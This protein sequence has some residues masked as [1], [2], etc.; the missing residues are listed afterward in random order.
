MLHVDIPTL[1]DVKSLVAARAD[2]CVSIYL[3]TTP[4]TQKTA[5]SRI[6]LGNLWRGAA[7]QLE[8]AAFDKRR[9][10]ALE[11]QIADLA[12][13]RSFWRTQANSLAVLAT[14]ETLRTFRLPN[15]LV[16]Q[17]EVSDRFFLKP[18]LR[19]ITFPQVAFVLALSEG[20]VRLIEVFPDQPPNRVR[21]RAL[22]KDAGDATRRAS[23]NDRSPSGRIQ[24]G[25]GQKVLLRQFARRVD[26]ALR[27]VLAGRDVPL[28]LAATE[29]LEPIYRSVCT[30]ARLAAP[31]I[32]ASPD[33]MSDAELAEAARGV[34]DRLY[35]ADVADIRSLYEI[36]T[37]QDRTTTD[38]ARAARAAT[39]GNIECLMVDIEAAAPGRVDAETGKVS[40]AN[41]PGAGSYDIVDEVAGRTLLSGGRVLGV[42]AGDLPAEGQLAA[43]LRYPL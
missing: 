10:A 23:V 28:I 31:A 29:P 25:E 12:A 14:P 26:A 33:R 4:L 13:D 8:A 18:L 5:A 32:A 37:G 30:Y 19:A 42:R 24:G 9:L 15:R 40:F 27:A 3:P 7:A 22:P 11:E 43:I 21:I 34:L 6:R 38:I 39:V 2:A 20:A 17:I 36:R 35:A 16:E 41:E 1:A